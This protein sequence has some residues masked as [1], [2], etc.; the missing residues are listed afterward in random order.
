MSFFF[1]I[2]NAFFGYLFY[3]FY[4]L[5]PAWGMIWISLVT[6][7]AMLIIFRFTSNQQGIKKAK[8]KVSAY[9]LEMR[10]YSHDLTKMLAAMGKTFLSNFI[11]LRYMIFPIIFIIVPV[12]IVLIQTSFRYENR[13]LQTGA[14]VIVKAVLKSPFPV[15]ET[16]V[17]LR[18][19]A[20]VTIETPALRIPA[21]SEIDWRISVQKE[22][23]YE[24]S[25]EVNDRQYKK[26]LH[27]DNKLTALSRTRAGSSFNTYFLN[28]SEHRLPDDSP[29]ISLN[30]IYP[31]RTFEIMGMEMH[32]IVWFLIFS[33]VFSFAFK[34]LFKV[35]L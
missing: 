24:L 33:I 4:N 12:L 22:G 34:D 14:Q 1:K 9:I 31:A 29:F 16:P 21:L 26:N 17:N 15:L 6:G 35:A 30:I 8:A 11:Y 32:W 2:V 18:V 10:L 27:A 5:D 7:I 23:I 25:F 3:P 28:H 19:P 20:D 13:P